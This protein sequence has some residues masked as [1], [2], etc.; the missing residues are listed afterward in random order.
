MDGNVS[1]VTNMSSMFKDTSFNQ[2]IGKWNTR[3]VIN[4]SGMFSGAKFNQSINTDGD[5]WNTENVTALQT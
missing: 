1:I 2:P 3:E 5:K 4:M